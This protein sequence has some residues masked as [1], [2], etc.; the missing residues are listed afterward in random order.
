MKNDTSD[1]L[2]R[3]DGTKTELFYLIVPTAI[4]HKINV[5]PSNDKVY[6]HYVLHK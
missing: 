6:L 5:L 1:K 2:V 4:T 3:I